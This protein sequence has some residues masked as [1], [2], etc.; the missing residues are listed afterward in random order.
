MAQMLR[1]MNRA[2]V[3]HGA[4]PRRRMQAALAFGLPAT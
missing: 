4:K 3:H 2:H 1:E